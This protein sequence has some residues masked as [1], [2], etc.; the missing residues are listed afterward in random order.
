MT[1]ALTTSLLVGLVA[2]MA[3]HP[4]MPRHSTPF[5]LQFALGWLINEQPFLG[6]AWLA[7]GTAGVL[8]HPRPDRPLWWLVAALTA[9]D[10]AVLARLAWRT[11]SARPAL[12]A[13]L[14]G[15]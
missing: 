15:A 9:F 13:A 1:G 11:R 8:G 10:V 14:E 7:S 12:S 5:N 3:L 4:P 2:V 6:L